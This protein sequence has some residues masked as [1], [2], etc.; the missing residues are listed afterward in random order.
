MAAPAWPDVNK[1]YLRTGFLGFL[2]TS[3]AAE[4]ICMVIR[5]QHNSK[6]VNKPL[7]PC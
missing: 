5:K 6:T 4:T 1:K 7:S 2:G 3:V